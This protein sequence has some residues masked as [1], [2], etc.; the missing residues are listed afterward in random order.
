MQV[1]RPFLSCT[2]LEDLLE[3]VKNDKNITESAEENF[4][5]LVVVNGNLEE[6][7]LWFDE[8]EVGGRRE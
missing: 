6:I 4:Q 1:M 2:D 7:R 8:S 3:R 5:S